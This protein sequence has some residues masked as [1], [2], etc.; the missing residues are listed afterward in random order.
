VSEPWPYASGM[1]VSREL[2][3]VPPDH[4]MFHGGIGFVFEH[5]LPEDDE[6]LTVQA[7]RFIARLRVA[8]TG[9]EQQ[10]KHG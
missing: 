5:E 9:D 8:D 10:P 6:H 1:R 2:K 7:A 4:P 3:P